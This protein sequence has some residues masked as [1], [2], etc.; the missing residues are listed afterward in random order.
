LLKSENIPDQIL[1]LHIGNAYK[2]NNNV[3]ISHFESRI[4]LFENNCIDR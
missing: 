3:I 4:E 2:V 1:V